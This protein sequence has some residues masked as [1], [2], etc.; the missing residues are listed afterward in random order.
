MVARA[1]CRRCQRPPARIAKL[2]TA[3]RPPTWNASTPQSPM[4]HNHQPGLRSASASKTFDR[5][6]VRSRVIA[7][8][9]M[10]ARAEAADA[11]QPGS[12]IAR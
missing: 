5:R 12:A 7:I 1:R 3:K 11:V 4:P 6:V 8:H 10:A 2:A 9:P